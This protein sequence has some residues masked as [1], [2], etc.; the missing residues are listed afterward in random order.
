[1][2]YWYWN[3]SHPNIGIGLGPNNNNN[4]NIITSIYYKKYE[5]KNPK[6]PAQETG[7]SLFSATVDRKQTCSPS[8]N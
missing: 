4:D 2:I 6:G 8:R 7:F 1:M 5:M 3:Y